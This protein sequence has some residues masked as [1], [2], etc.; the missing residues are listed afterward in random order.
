MNLLFLCSKNRVRGPTAV[1]LF[2]G[3][4]GLDVVS[5]GTDI[6]ANR[7]VTRDLLRKADV[8]FAMEQ[9]HL[10][11]LLLRFGEA[12]RHE[13]LQKTVVLDIDTRFRLM[14][15]TLIDLLITR[16]ADVMPGTIPVADLRRAYPPP[17]TISVSCWGV[18]A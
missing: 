15:D 14:D 7:V 11:V 13:L 12:I 5:A 8:I 18:L 17:K 9:R 16:V 10:D 6:D 2:S 3:M 1:R 4:P